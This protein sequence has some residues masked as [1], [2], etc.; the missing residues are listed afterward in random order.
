M[1]TDYM[2]KIIILFQKLPR[3]TIFHWFLCFPLFFWWPFHDWDF[4]PVILQEEWVICRAFKKGSGGNKV[5]ISGLLNSVDSCFNL[6]PLAD[7]SSGENTRHANAA[8][9]SHVTCFS[10]PKQDHQDKSLE[11]YTT[12]SNA[13]FLYPRHQPRDAFGVWSWTQ[14][15]RRWWSRFSDHFKWANRL[16]FLVELLI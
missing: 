15:L 1:S 10:N 14:A 11:E 5:H 3:F 13:N 8:E 6:P 16:R 2:E 9:E 12:S 4:F 7:L